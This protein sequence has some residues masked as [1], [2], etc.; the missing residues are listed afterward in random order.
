M[1]HYRMYNLEGFKLLG[2]DELEAGSETE[3]VEAAR[4]SGTGD[5]VE[6]WL[7]SRKV[8]VV[9]PSRTQSR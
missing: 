2:S 1:T 9:A 6:L 8:R 3:A 5:R 7:G 4:K